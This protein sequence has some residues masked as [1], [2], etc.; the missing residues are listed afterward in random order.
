M[1]KKINSIIKKY[2][3]FF[4]TKDLHN[5]DLIFSPNIILKD[6]AGSAKGKNRVLD[7]NKKI[8]K[9][10]KKIKIKLV[11]ICYN[12]KKNVYSC[13]I[14]ISLDKIKLSVIDLLYFDQNYKIKKIE[15]YK[16]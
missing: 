16:I 9:K 15:A 10:F 2:F 11:L 14:I 4:S 6:W 3:Y 7:F 13:K 1:K 5:L 12:E 8:F